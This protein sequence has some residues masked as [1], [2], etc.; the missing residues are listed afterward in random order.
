MLKEGRIL[1]D[2]TPN[3]IFEEAT[4]IKENQLELPFVIEAREVLIQHGLSIPPSIQ[5]KEEL[6]KHLWTLS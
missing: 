5:T 6:V 3:Q 1:R 4:V 2:G